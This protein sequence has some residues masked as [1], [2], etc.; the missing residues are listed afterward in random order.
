MSDYQVTL[1]VD[2]SVKVLRTVKA[3]N[4][5]DAWEMAKSLASDLQLE[6]LKSDE[7]DVADVDDVDIVSAKETS[8]E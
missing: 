5:D 8:H 6:D 7:M 1:N 2:L 3:D 4:R